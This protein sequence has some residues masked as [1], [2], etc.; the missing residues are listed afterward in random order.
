L[1][2][3]VPF[4]W[5][6][7]VL[8]GCFLCRFF[9]VGFSLSVVLSVSLF[10]GPCWFPCSCGVGGSFRWF[11]L[12]VP[13]VVPVVVGVGGSF[14]F[15][16]RRQPKAIKQ[17]GD[18]V[19]SLSF[20]L[21]CS[22]GACTASAVSFSRQELYLSGS[23]APVFT[24]L[25]SGFGTVRRGPSTV[26]RSRSPVHQG[27]TGFSGPLIGAGCRVISAPRFCHPFYSPYHPT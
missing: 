7:R 2:S 3:L 5:C 19:S 27:E 21:T 13:V 26:L 12:V 18:P 16:V 22:G 14:R 23:L 20:A 15:I 1:V 10:S 11:L 25:G 9:P 6:F 8:S 24:A 4:L 17:P